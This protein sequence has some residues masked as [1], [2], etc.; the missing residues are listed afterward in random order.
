MQEAERERKQLE[1]HYKHFAHDYLRFNSELLVSDRFENQVPVQPTASYR[2]SRNRY[3]Y[4]NMATVTNLPDEPEQD[5]PRAGT[6]GTNQDP[7]D[8]VFDDFPSLVGDPDNAVPFV[9]T[10]GASASTITAVHLDLP[11]PA[12]NLNSS[13]GPMN[14]STEKSEEI[15]LMLLQ[16]EREALQA[17][18]GGVPV[19]VPSNVPSN[20]KLDDDAG[21]TYHDVSEGSSPD[22]AFL[23]DSVS[24][25]TLFN[26]LQTKDP[27]AYKQFLS[28]MKAVQP[29]KR[30]TAPSPAPKPA[31]AD[32]SSAL[33]PLLQTY[34]SLDDETKKEIW[35]GALK[36]LN[37]QLIKRVSELRKP[38]LNKTLL[39]KLTKE[40][41][42]HAEK[43]AVGILK[44]DDNASKRRYN[45][46]RWI[47]GITTVMEMFKETQGIIVVETIKSF[48]DPNCVGNQSVFILVNSRV[49]NYFRQVL[50]RVPK[51]GE[52]A[53][54]LLQTLCA[55]VTSNDRHHYHHLFTNMKIT[56]NE[57]ATHFL[58]RF[59]I[60][61][62]QS[63]LV[64]NTYQDDTSLLL[65]QI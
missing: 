46:Q 43:Q 33:E 53:L 3:A 31:Q 38:D 1:E 7:G 23:P 18:G 65:S 16:R 4:A 49:D 61:R 29:P 54:Q 47:T 48:K 14:I 11:T 22:E 12:R 5:T 40:L 8:S 34:E 58:Y 52:K 35:L 2:P 42:T 26:W 62:N 19:P 60:G 59:I 44:Y 57:S 17:S 55:N 15:R 36:S 64:G 63:E 41:L 32:I 9:S 6:A 28:D 50:T 25:T 24:S 37:P 56:T 13:F 21:S 20:L 30:S 27:A 45:Y 39:P 10:D 51:F